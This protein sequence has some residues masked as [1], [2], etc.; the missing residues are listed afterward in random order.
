MSRQGEPVRRLQAAAWP[1]AAVWRAALASA[2]L[3][4]VLAAALLAAAP[5]SRAI[6]Q[7][8]PLPCPIDLDVGKLEAGDLVWPR[9][10]AALLPYGTAS[11]DQERRAWDQE[12]AAYLRTLEGRALSEAEQRDKLRIAQMSYREFLAQYVEGPGL[13]PRGFGRFVGHVAIVDVEPGGAVFMIEA[14]LA[15]GVVRTALA[16]WAASVCGDVFWHG[17][18]K[19]A[20]LDQRR[21]IAAEARRHVGKPYSILKRRLDDTSGFYCSKLAWLAIHRA[22]GAAPDNNP[23]AARW[24]WFSPRQLIEAEVVELKQNPGDY[25]RPIVPTKQLPPPK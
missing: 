13:A 6:A 24:T 20:T 16:A 8:Q 1:A 18:V 2:F 25:R 22:T 12:K 15:K 4:T 3:T 14:L 23:E 10:A 19:T 21:Q 7:S 11:E 9:K 17:R 5:P